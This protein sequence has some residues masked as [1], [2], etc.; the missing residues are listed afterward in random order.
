MAMKCVLLQSNLR[1]T[2]QVN[3]INVFCARKY[4]CVTQKGNLKLNKIIT[5]IVE[6]SRNF[7][8]LKKGKYNCFQTNK[9]CLTN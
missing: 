6:I 3:K 9:N 5:H 8:L 4:F 1:N 7:Q 2:Y